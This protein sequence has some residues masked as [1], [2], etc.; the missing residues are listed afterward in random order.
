VAST[1]PIDAT[2]FRSFFKHYASG[3][4]VITTRTPDGPQ[5]LTATSV[6]ALSLDPPL[7]LVCVTQNSRT[8]MTI[9]Q[10]GLFAVHLLRAD[11]S[12][13]CRR[14]SALEIDGARKFDGLKMISNLPVPLIANTFSWVACERWAEYNGGDHAIIV[15]RLL[16]SSHPKEGSVPLIWFGGR[17]CYPE[18]VHNKPDF[19]P[20]V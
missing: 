11:Q 15:G 1:F 12:G 13:L 10:S 4:S 18:S 17:S 7:L 3:V 20:V 5:G 9:A 6:C 8:G 14:F 16:K 2:G 19:S